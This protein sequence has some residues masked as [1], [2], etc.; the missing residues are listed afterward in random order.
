MSNILTQEERERILGLM[1]N[2]SAPPG[3]TDV[4]PHLIAI[5]S[6]IEKIPMADLNSVALSIEKIPE[7]IITLQGSAQAIDKLRSEIENL[8][9]QV[10]EIVAMQHDFQPLIQAVNANTHAIANA[11]HVLTAVMMAPKRVEFGEDGRP[12]GIMID[13]HGS[14]N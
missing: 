13:S 10:S 7:A 8:T 14:P 6:A 4:S 5:V 2:P 9:K 12:V 1:R 3:Q 11:A